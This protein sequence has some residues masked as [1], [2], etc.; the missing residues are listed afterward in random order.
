[1]AT[2]SMFD[3]GKTLIKSSGEAKIYGRFNVD[4][5]FLASGPISSGNWSNTTF[6]NN[7]DYITLEIFS[8][9]ARTNRLITYMWLDS[10]FTASG[11]WYA[12]KSFSTAR[13][14]YPGAN[15]DTTDF[16]IATGTSPGPMS[17]HHF[18]IDNRP[19]PAA[20][21]TGYYLRWTAWQNYTTQFGMS[22]VR[23]VSV[24]SGSDTRRG[25][26]DA[27][28]AF[29]GIPRLS[30]YKKLN[31]G[32]NPDYWHTGV[33]ITNSNLNPNYR[34]DIDIDGGTISEASNG[35]N[36]YD[37]SISANGDFETLFQN[38]TGIATNINSTTANRFAFRIKFY[39]N[40]IGGATSL[41]NAFQTMQDIFTR[42]A[43]NDGELLKGTTSW[44]QINRTSDINGNALVAVRP[45]NNNVVYTFFI[46]QAVIIDKEE[47]V[48]SGGDE[49]IVFGEYWSAFPNGDVN[50]MHALYVPPLYKFDT[51]T[52]SI[53]NQSY[54]YT[55]GTNSN[56]GEVKDAVYALSIKGEVQSETIPESSVTDLNLLKYKAEKVTLE[57]IKSGTTQITS[58]D[59]VSGTILDDRQ[60]NFSAQIGPLIDSFW[61]N[62][63][64]RFAF[65]AYDANDNE[66]AVYATTVAVNAGE[67]YNFPLANIT[68]GSE[69]VEILQNP[70]QTGYPVTLDKILLQT[71]E[72][73]SAHRKLKKVIFDVEKNGTSV[74]SKT[75]SRYNPNTGLLYTLSQA[76]SYNVTNHLIEE[77]AS[78]YTAS[79]ALKNLSSH[80]L[81]VRVYG[82]AADGGDLELDDKKYNIY[83]ETRKSWTFAASN[84]IQLSD[85][86]A[87]HYITNDGVSTWNISKIRVYAGDSAAAAHNFHITYAFHNGSSWGGHTYRTITGT[88]AANTLTYDALRNQY[89]LSLEGDNL[90]TTEEMNS[91]FTSIYDNA[92]YQFHV[93][94]AA[95]NNEGGEMSYVYINGYY[96][97]STE[98]GL[99]SADLDTTGNIEIVAHNTGTTAK[100]K[101]IKALFR[102][103]KNT[104]TNTYT[105][106]AAYFR[107]DLYK[108]NSTASADLL[109][110][111]Y[112]TGTGGN[113]QSHGF[114]KENFKRHNSLAEYLAD[115]NGHSKV[116][117]GDIPGWGTTYGSTTFRA[118]LRAL[119]DNGNFLSHKEEAVVFNTHYQFVIDQAFS[120]GLEYASDDG[121]TN[122]M[123]KVTASFQPTVTANNAF[124]YAVLTI[125]NVDDHT[126]QIV[127]TMSPTTGSIFEGLSKYTFDT[128][129][130]HS[131]L[132]D[133]YTE[134]KIH[135]KIEVFAYGFQSPSDQANVISS[136]HASSISENFTVPA[137]QWNFGSASVQVLNQDLLNCNMV[138]NFAASDASL[139]TVDRIKFK[140]INMTTDESK[141]FF[142]DGVSFSTASQQ[143]T[144]DVDGN[145][146]DIIDLVNETTRRELSNNLFQYQLIGQTY[147][148]G[149]YT[150]I[151]KEGGSQTPTTTS[152]FSLSPLSFVIQN[153]SASL[154]TDAIDSTILNIAI[155]K[156]SSIHVTN[157]MDIKIKESGTLSGTVNTAGNWTNHSI[158]STHNFGKITTN[159]GQRTVNFSVDITG[160]SNVDRFD[161]HQLT[162]IAR[163]VYDVP[164][165]GSYYQ[166]NQ[167]TDFITSV[168]GWKPYFKIKESTTT[169]DL[170]EQTI[171]N[172]SV[173]INVRGTHSSTSTENPAGFDFR[174]KDTVTNQTM[175]VYKSFSDAKVDT[176]GVAGELNININSLFSS[177]KDQDRDVECEIV[178][179]F[180]NASGTIID[181]PSI[182]KTL[183]ISKEPKIE[184]QIS[185]LKGM[186]IDGAGREYFA[187]RFQPQLDSMAGFIPNNGSVSIDFT[188]KE[189]KN[190]STI[191]TRTYTLTGAQLANYHAITIP[192]GVNIYADTLTDSKYYA[193]VRGY[194][195]LKRSGNYTV[196][197]TLDTTTFRDDTGNTFQ[198]VHH[199]FP[200]VLESL[201]HTFDGDDGK[202]IFSFEKL[203]GQTAGYST[204][205][206]DAWQF[207]ITA[208]EDVLN[209]IDTG[210]VGNTKIVGSID[211]GDFDTNSIPW[212]AEIPR[213]ANYN[214]KIT[215][216]IIEK[217]NNNRAIGNN[218]VSHFS[219]SVN[220]EHPDNG[221]VTTFCPDWLTLG[222]IQQ[223]RIFEKTNVTMNDLAN[224]AN[225]TV[226]PTN[227][228][229][230]NVEGEYA[231]PN[232][233]FTF[234]V[235]INFDEYF[236]NA[237]PFFSFGL[238]VKYYGSDGV[239]RDSLSS[240]IDSNGLLIKSSSIPAEKL[241]EIQNSST[242]LVRDFA[243]DGDTYSFDLI[244]NQDG[245]DYGVQPSITSSRKIQYILM[246]YISD[247]L[248][249]YNSDGKITTTPVAFN[250][251]ENWQ[252]AVVA[253]E[254]DWY[255]DGRTA[256]WSPIYSNFN[257]QPQTDDKTK[258]DYSFGFDIDDIKKKPYAFSQMNPKWRGVV[259]T[260][261]GAIIGGTNFYSPS[262]HHYDGGEIGPDVYDFNISELDYAVFNPFEDITFSFT[263]YMIM[264]TKVKNSYLYGW[265]KT[266][267]DLTIHHTL[268]Y[269]DLIVPSFDS[270]SVDHSLNEDTIN[271][272]NTQFTNKLVFFFNKDKLK[273]VIKV[274]SI[275][276]EW[277]TMRR[278][279]LQ[280][281]QTLT[282]GQSVRIYPWGSTP[283][284]TSHD[285]NTNK[286]TY[287]DAN[288]DLTKYSGLDGD[289]PFVFEYELTPTFRRRAS[290]TSSSTYT[291]LPEKKISTFL[292]PDEFPYANNGVSGLASKSIHE[293]KHSIHLKWNHTYTE[294]LDTFRSVDAKIF[295]DLYWYVDETDAQKTVKEGLK[296]KRRKFERISKR[297]DI[298]S[299]W[300]FIDTVEYEYPSSPITN[301]NYEFSYLWK[302]DKLEAD[303]KMIVAVITRI[304]S[305]V[306][307]VLSQSVGTVGNNSIEIGVVK[308]SDK[309][310][311][312]KLHNDDEL[313][314]TPNRHLKREQEFTSSL[315]QIPFTV[316]RKKAKPRGSDKP[317]SSST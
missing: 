10:Q 217:Y 255:A 269:R 106:Q 304:E 239:Q 9:S 49:E 65:T 203:A 60:L 220:L 105:G 267:N 128:V 145:S 67:R 290:D 284:R 202:L 29:S 317:Y 211:A 296:P 259:K 315:S 124:D 314:R 235:P 76:Q 277:I 232:K 71:T 316:T 136:W 188:I 73:S 4:I 61:E 285:A 108:N 153:V 99:D 94:V 38:R 33:R 159:A 131:I 216:T 266:I 256:T 221:G 182:T 32:A 190:N 313:K 20:A 199:R 121:L 308:T 110:K 240:Y 264:N 53:T 238:K 151:A 30:F 187:C 156:Q 248:V 279:I 14:M 310:R 270:L 19:P 113:T 214:S 125:T 309:A 41:Q 230:T 54:V 117:L 50:S 11:N 154:S 257:V 107:M 44:A 236:T 45:T 28:Y 143:R 21:G 89:Y 109:G 59:V 169:F 144:T 7:V 226:V 297:Q 272:D 158:D 87:T 126:K 104:T 137:W 265:D 112:T 250:D 64:I 12:T 69:I 260:L 170:H 88:T 8:D 140:I 127:E 167:E 213:E 160:L 78:I 70:G 3:T 289:K 219:K 91:R 56:G 97:I 55:V 52:L 90:P 85:G 183:K 228:V 280:D 23:V 276:E 63:S 197:G 79:A 306:L 252:E 249:T 293:D 173:D 66:I 258:F 298:S 229:V 77:N 301:Q 36:W 101:S 72:T 201:S 303:T 133:R 134:T 195:N 155:T 81:R 210:S 84:P 2:T 47:K 179:R 180:P 178:P 233:R 57:V 295:F 222:L 274:F 26:H 242:Y 172:I 243:Q 135:W 18:G 96:Q 200:K 189:N 282:D 192:T 119:D 237:E 138:A 5:D 150:D 193:E 225:T 161:A 163:S 39:N 278:N 175:S 171:D 168:D 291:E 6:N 1:M 246:V 82:F 287:T 253:V 271:D 148:D 191:A 40:Y 305:E 118:I 165:G 212:D 152:N 48:W 16:S 157:R 206:S 262:S 31:T 115:T 103:E 299:N 147:A 231:A 209:A 114:I 247:E 51:S 149:K 245:F 22:A 181:G 46:L 92:G 300:N 205:R 177:Y 194:Y 261:G 98:R 25:S 95:L 268:N 27:Y 227:I 75:Y 42:S 184:F 162:V 283:T 37:T 15:F 263:P 58:N 86:V 204:N 186:F 251:I 302:Y 132:N 275:S 215:L 129:N 208:Q 224:Y 164:E 35:A 123:Y 74:Y 122:T 198:A 286:I 241:S 244:L 116:Y 307:G 93:R 254:D 13:K 100:R 273:D 17:T 166:S 312:N 68:N 176:S 142:L 207:D 139:D 130:I 281:G 34:V 141:E 288:I 223:T 102:R 43:Y 62:E 185:S 294:S 146:L 196:N 120:D 111:Y 24:T 218:S 80:Q 311:K 292:I 234:E 174:F 83:T